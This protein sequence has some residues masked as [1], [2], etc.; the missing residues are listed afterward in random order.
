MT[1]NLP[2]VSWALAFLAGAMSFLSP[3]VVPLIP[4]YLSYVSGVSVGDLHAS[5]PGVP[6]GC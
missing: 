3:C 5:V 1:P 6:A 4:G 2:P